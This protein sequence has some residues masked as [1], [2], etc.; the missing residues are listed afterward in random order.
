MIELEYLD[1]GPNIIKE[2]LE[3]VI[4]YKNNLK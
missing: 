4:Y 3:T 1:Y 2:I